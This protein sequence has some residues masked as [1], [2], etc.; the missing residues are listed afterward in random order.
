MKNLPKGNNHYYIVCGKKCNNQKEVM[1]FLGTK[2]RTTF[3]RMRAEGAIKRIE[4]SNL[5]GL[6]SNKEIENGNKERA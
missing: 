1:E 2:S 5:N 4:T 6:N 3:R